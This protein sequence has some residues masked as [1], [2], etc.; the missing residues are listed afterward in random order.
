MTEYDCEPYSEYYLKKKLLEQ[1]GE[2][3]VITSTPGVS[4]I[5]LVSKTATHI[6]KEYHE[7]IR[8]SS[9]EEHIKILKAAAKIIRDDVLRQKYVVD[10]YDFGDFLASTEEA[11]SFCPIK[12]QIFLGE[13]FTAKQ[14]KEKIMSIGQSTMQ[15]V[16]PRSMI[17]S[18]QVMIYIVMSSVLRLMF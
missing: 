17:A 14:S 13:L 3:L 11:L 6:V 16:R 8:K 18:L 5:V 9:E 12:L 7:S 2:D 1:F 15:A 10:K 4:D